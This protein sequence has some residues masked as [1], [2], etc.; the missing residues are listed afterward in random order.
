M[1]L[2]Q[3]GVKVFPL[4]LVIHPLKRIS[5]VS[6]M[7]INRSKLDTEVKATLSLFLLEQIQEVWVESVFD[8]K[9][10]SADVTACLDLFKS[11]RF[12]LK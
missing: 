2:A 10:P 7:R 3:S 5:V 12:V 8:L 4:C 6:Q 9:N 1:T 11:K